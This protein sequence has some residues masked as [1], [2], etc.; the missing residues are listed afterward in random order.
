MACGW[1]PDDGDD[2]APVAG[3]V[4]LF[5]NLHLHR[6]KCWVRFFFM[7]AIVVAQC[8]ASA[9]ITCAKRLC[10]SLKTLRGRMLMHGSMSKADVTFSCNQDT[11]MP[12]P[13]SCASQPGSM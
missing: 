10:Q 5:G 1:G 6:S 3:A 13:R 4:Y 2:H 9:T 7:H 11:L 8:P 12:H